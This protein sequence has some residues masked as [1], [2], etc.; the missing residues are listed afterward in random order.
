MP[1][2]A[3]SCWYYLRYI[4]PNNDQR[5]VDAAKESYW[6]PVDLYFVGAEHA[7]I[8]LLYRRFWHK[9]LYDLG[10]VSVPEPFQKLVNQGTILGEPEI[11]LAPDLYASHQQELERAGILAVARKGEEGDTVG[12]YVLKIRGVEPDELA[13]LPEERVA[14]EK[15]R[16]FLTEPRLEVTTK[17]EKMSKSRGNVVNPD[18]IV[19]DYGADAFRLYE[20]YMGPL[21]ASK[22]W[23]TRDIV[24]MTRFLN[25]VWRNLIGDEESRKAPTISD[26]PVP[27]ALARQ[28]HRAIKKVGEDVAAL[29][30]NTAIA[31]LIKLNNELT[32]LPTVPRRLAE[33]FTLLLAPF[34]PHLAEELWQRLGHNE[35]LARHAWP[36]Y[37]ESK[38]AESMLE[39][40]VQVNGKVRDKITV[41]ADA[42]EADILRV[43]EA[44]E[45]VRPWVEGKTLRKRLY[46]PKK[47]VNLVV[48]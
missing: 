29:R 20:M 47:L 1:Q 44:S 10:L 6:M 32:G 5:F 43:A 21:E 2:W 23:N 14:K 27:D 15:G 45:R 35:S 31:E 18:T 19:R 25:G 34:A 28:L 24:G 26:E 11:H 7:V 17:A 42:A 37:D 9:V 4:D 30:F 48:G 3:G 16:I 33:T 22:P 46:V 39:L 36:Q 13:N 38:L 40:P 12:S 41:P 8:H